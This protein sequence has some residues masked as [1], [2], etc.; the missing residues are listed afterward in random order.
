VI[1]CVNDYRNSAS[2]QT[3]NILLQSLWIKC[4]IFCVVFRNIHHVIVAMTTKSGSTFRN[5]FDK[6]YKTWMVI[7]E[8][9]FIFLWFFVY[10]VNSRAG[11]GYPARG[12]KMPSRNFKNVIVSLQLFYKT[13]TKWFS[14][15]DSVIHAL[16]MLLDFRKV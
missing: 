8:A 15:Q 2:S 13:I 14:K 6:S 3:Q 4:I 10:L 12:I 11:S 1:L 5:S 7:I 16:G 9:I